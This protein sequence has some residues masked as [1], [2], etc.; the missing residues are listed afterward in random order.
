MI[1]R[2]SLYD[3]IYGLSADGPCE[4]ALYGSCAP[5]ARTA[6]ERSLIGD[7]FPLIWFEVPLTGEA[8]FDLHV[9]LS[10][11]SLKSGVSFL[12]GAGSGYDELFRWYA[13]EE[14]G[15]AGL[16]FAYDVSEGRIDQP[17]VHVNVNNAPLADIHRFFDLAAGDGAAERYFGFV[18]RLPHAWRVWYTGVHPGRPG[19]P[20]RVDCFVNHEGKTRYQKDISLFEADLKALGFE[21]ISPALF[22]VAQLVLSSPYNLELQFD[23][24][25]DGTCGPTIGISA[26]FTLRAATLMRSL[27]EGDGVA[28]QLMEGIEKLGLADSRWHYVPRAIYSMLT[29]VEEER[30]TL[31]CLPTFVKM[32]VRDG[33]PLDA[34]LYFQASA[35]IAR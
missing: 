32:R 3:A 24:M 23:V 34:K 16:A 5:M 20:V 6:F 7:E 31:Y 29:N 14:V 27:F 12:P 17:A 35:Q 9:A 8:R 25:A 21:A 26:A 11:G 22:D 30:I 2:L 4:E 13:E 19:S 18:A 10:R 28:A 33:V 1:D 15:G